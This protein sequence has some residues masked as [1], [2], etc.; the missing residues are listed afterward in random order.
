MEAGKKREA[1]KIGSW[2]AEK[3]EAGKIGSWEAEKMEAGKLGKRWKLGSWGNN[4]Q[5]RGEV[6]YL[7]GA[8]NLR[9]PVAFLI[10]DLNREDTR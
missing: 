4:Y 2:E 3:R 6:I 8:N 9:D 7:P 1:G 5:L 10:C